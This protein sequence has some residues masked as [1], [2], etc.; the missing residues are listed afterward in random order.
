MH[1]DNCLSTPSVLSTSDLL[2]LLPVCT[3][4]SLRILS[5]VTP[6]DA[7]CSDEFDKLFVMDR[8]LQG[9]KKGKQ[10]QQQQ[11]KQQQGKIVLF[12]AKRSMNMGIG[13]ARLNISNRVV[14]RCLMEGVIRDPDSNT[15]LEPPTLQALCEVMPTSDEIQVVTHFRGDKTRLSEAER[16]ALAV[17][18]VPDALKRTQSLHFMATFYRTC[19][20]A[21]VHTGRLVCPPMAHVSA[22]M[23]HFLRGFAGA[24]RQFRATQHYVV[25]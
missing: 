21:C 22:M 1:G 12:D 23:A 13:L 16:F 9:G 5:G 2:V 20:Q 8:A 4:C 3:D 10:K 14:Q 25:G 11:K 19:I 6:A 18:K 15:V 24:M 7:L 17:C